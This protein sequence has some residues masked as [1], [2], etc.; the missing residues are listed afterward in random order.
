VKQLINTAIGLAAHDKRIDQR[1][2]FLWPI[3]LAAPIV[4][5]P[6]EGDKARSIEHI[7][8]ERRRS[9]IPRRARS[10]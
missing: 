6:K 3:G 5:A 4:R 8:P 1:R 9:G 10:A 7:A 2:D